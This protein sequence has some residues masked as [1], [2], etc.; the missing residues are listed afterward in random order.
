MS[1][2]KQL[3]RSAPHKEGP[4]FM[5][6]KSDTLARMKHAEEYHPDMQDSVSVKLFI[7][8]L[9]LTA[10]PAPDSSTTGSSSEESAPENSDGGTSN[11]SEDA[12]GQDGN[13]PTDESPTD[14]T[15]TGFTLLSTTED[16]WEVLSTGYGFVSMDAGEG[17]VL[18]PMAETSGETHAAWVIAKTTQ[19]TPIKDFI[20]D[21]EITVESQLRTPTPEPWEVFWFFF[22]YRS[23]G[24]NLDNET[25][26]FIYKPNGYEF[27]RAFEG[28]GEQYFFYLNPVV[29]YYYSIGDTYQLRVKKVGQTVSIFINGVFVLEQTG[30]TWPDQFY[31]IPGAFVLYTEDAVVRITYFA[32]QSLD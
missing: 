4:L 3:L 32:F 29:Q 15:P 31:D 25:N 18:S 28:D 6:Y 8:L 10:C 12:E 5:R 17:I 30:T 19:T 14:G 16:D 9:L 11:D 20:A 24:P 26:Y 2:M 23:T 1:G 21:M 13:N 27:G 22:N 7:L